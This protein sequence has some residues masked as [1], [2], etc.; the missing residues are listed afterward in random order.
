MK[1][2]TILLCSVIFL[3]SC[4]Q[5]E[6]ILKKNPFTEDK[7]VETSD[8]PNNQR[9]VNGPVLE[10]AYFNQVQE[11][12]GKK[13]IMNPENILALVNKEFSLPGE[14]RPNDLVRPNVPFSF[15][16]SDAEKSLMRKEA[17]KALEKLFAQAK[18]ENIEIFAVSG[19]RSYIRQKTLFDVEVANSG[20]EKAEQVVAVP[21]QSEH[22]TGLTMDIASRATNLE[23]TEAFGETK[24]GKWLAENAH[25]FGFILR[26]PKG[27]EHITNYQYEPWHFRY[28]GTEA[29]KTMYKND[30][31]LEEFFQEVEKI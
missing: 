19:Y 2:L 22:Q 4:S 18:K 17:A 13:E 1:K 8:N 21:G 29:A 28:V 30:W 7:E 20:L 11:T 12:S 15:G 10:A 24:E 26:Y 14:Y 5:I 31:T 27:K 16:E 3:A 23:L 9:A 25:K 6:S